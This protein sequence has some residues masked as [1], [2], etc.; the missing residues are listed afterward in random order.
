MHGPGGEREHPGG[1]HASSTT[2]PRRRRSPQRTGRRTRTGGTGRRSRSRSRR[3]RGTSPG[4]TPVAH[5]SATRARTTPR[6]RVREP[7]PTWPGTRAPP[8]PSP[9]ST[10]PLRR[11]PPAA[12]IGRPTRTGGTTTRSRS[13]SSAGCNLRDRLLLRAD[14]LGPDGR[15]SRSPDPAPTVPGTRTRTSPRPEVRRDATDASGSLARGPDANGWYNQPV[16]FASTGRTR[17][18]IASARRL[19][20][21][22]GTSRTASGNCTTSRQHQRTG[23]GHDRL[24]RDASRDDARCAGPGCER[25]VQPAGR[26]NVSSD[27]IRARLV[28]GRDLR[29]GGAAGAASARPAGTV[30]RQLRRSG[31][32]RR[33]L[34]RRP[35]RTAATAAGTARPS[36]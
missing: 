6:R 3:R 18:G 30:S 21:P 7:A 9:S 22:D 13:A 35:S 15:T 24:R 8:P 32:T 27:G 17:L 26:A 33:R 4:R 11:P 12:W 1:R 25:L 31:T 16:A 20:R 36:P 5:P 29:P 2:R 28:L 14:V 34:R 23:H 10:T 19:R